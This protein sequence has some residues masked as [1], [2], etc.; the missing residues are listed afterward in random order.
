VLLLDVYL[1]NSSLCCV[2][3]SMV[4]STAACVALERVC[5][6][7]LCAAPGR[8]CL[9]QTV[10]HLSVSVYK[11]FVLHLDVSVYNSQCCTC[12]CLSTRPHPMLYWYCIKKSGLFQNRYVCFGYFDTC[13][14]HRNKV[15][16]LVFGFRKQTEKH[17][18]PIK[19]RYYPKIFLLV[20]RTLY[21]IM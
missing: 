10:L 6:Q 17:S 13:S 21:T 2:R 8:V 20:S 12:A 5:L 7:E 1:F 3:K 19:F 4:R 18:R 11:S 14:K 16:N 15:K 9:Q